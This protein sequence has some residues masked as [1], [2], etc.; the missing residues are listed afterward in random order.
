MDASSTVSDVLLTVDP[1]VAPRVADVD[2]SPPVAVCT[3]TTTVPED[4][5]SA[6]FAS[7]SNSNDGSLEEEATGAATAMGAAATDSATARTTDNAATATGLEARFPDS[8]FARALQL[9]QESKFEQ[10]IPVE[11]FLDQCG[12]RYEFCRQTATATA[13]KL[14]VIDVRSPCEFGK[15][16]IPGATN[17][18]LFTDEQRAQVGTHFKR[19]G[20]EPAIRLGVKL[21]TPVWRELLSTAL[22]VADECG[23]GSPKFFVY[24]FRGGMRSGSCAFLLQEAGLECYTLAGG[25][26]GFRQWALQSFTIP[27]Q[28]CVIGGRTGTGKT[29]V[30]LSLR[31]RGCQVLDLEGEA[32]HLG[33]AFGHLQHGYGNQPTTEQFENQCAVQWRQFDSDKLVFMEDEGRHCGTCTLPLELFEQKQNAERLVEIT[34]PIEDRVQRLVQT[35][36][37]ASVEQL[38]NCAH[39]IKKNMGPQRTA[40]FIEAVENKNLAAGAEIALAYYDKLYDKFLQSKP[41][42]A[43]RLTVELVGADVAAH[44]AAVVHALS[45]WKVDTGACDG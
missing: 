30:L 18:P 39:R 4:T 17:V 20:R 2:S 32:K 16:H 10:R 12:L 1:D 5:P 9:A 29:D 19:A 3:V 13:F 23:G 40:E 15:G 43:Q 34:L 45:A 37:T 44:S 22:G 26:K 25:Y 42:A 41:A 28:V 36:G 31:R 6:S 21:I 27:R 33:S 11:E 38:V 7:N 14:P 24:C 8:L 35:Y